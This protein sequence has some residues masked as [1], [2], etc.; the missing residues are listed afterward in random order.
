MTLPKQIKAAF[1]NTPWLIPELAPEDKCFIGIFKDYPYP[2]QA[3]WSELYKKWIYVIIQCDMGSGEWNDIYFQNE[4]DNKEDLIA[5][6][7]MEE[8]KCKINKS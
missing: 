8:W 4:S 1:E 7:P 6:I 5:W 3:H 2:A